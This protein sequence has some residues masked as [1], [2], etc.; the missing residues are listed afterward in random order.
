MIPADLKDISSDH[1]QALVA[2]RVEEGRTLEFKRE[3][4]GSTREARKEFIADVCAMAN[5]AGGDI[6]YGVDEDREGRATAINAVSFNPDELVL[7]LSSVLA[8]GLEPRL[9][10]IV[11]RPVEIRD[12]TRVL[13]IRVPRAHNGLH[14]SAQ[15]R[16]FWVRESRSKQALDVPGI[17]SR[18][19]AL[20][21]REDRLVDF[22][23]RRY[24]AIST[25]QC[26][27]ALQPGQKV[28]VH[29]LP[30]HEF[31]DGAEV[32]LE[33]V[34]G[35]GTFPVMPREHGGD[36][37]M[38]L[39]GVMH[40]PGI[41]RGA[42]RAFT[43]LFHSGVV[44]AV[45]SLGTSTEGA[46]T[47]LRFE[48]VEDYILGFLQAALPRASQHL[49]DGWPILARF[50]IV[51]AHLA[52]AEPA[53]RTRFFLDDVAPVRVF[54]P[55]LALPEVLFESDPGTSLPTFLRP[56]FDRLWQAWGYVRSYSYQQGRTRFDRG[57]P[58]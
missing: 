28:V 35:P 26:S 37:T 54:E 8:D 58:R 47:N 33:P 53:D 43:L 38:T 41:S 44:E 2:G 56:A 4:P 42:V 21:G 50:A 17:T 36:R 7:Q 15:D 20:F 30:A 16:G 55:V 6:V 51:G 34:V 22:L 5:T 11:M 23:A 18:F 9:H 19:R 52:G 25:N 45:A 46:A 57:T 40:H 49:S 24:A 31:L 3:L 12:G 13:V 1:I 29:L 10:G 14:R 27:L 48:V 32:N 39:D